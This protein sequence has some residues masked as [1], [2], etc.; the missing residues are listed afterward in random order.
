MQ[1]HSIEKTRNYDA[2]TTRIRICREYRATPL[3]FAPVHESLNIMNNS[4]TRRLTWQ[5]H[6]HD[7]HPHFLFFHTFQQ[8]KIATL[9]KSC[10]KH[11]P[12]TIAKDRCYNIAECNIFFWGE[13][14]R[15]CY[16]LASFWRSKNDGDLTKPFWVSISQIYTKK[17][18][19]LDIWCV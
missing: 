5:S 8:R 14:N 12:Y 6:T 4:H 2:R 3:V 11:T 10:T 19:R 18:I 13:K 1:T 17:C 7:C 15:F 16:V 9:V